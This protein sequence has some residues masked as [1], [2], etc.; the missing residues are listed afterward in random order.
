MRARALVVIAVLAAPLA[1]AEQ[2]APTPDS[3]PVFGVRAGFG[4]P[5]G[6]TAQR[7]PEV[8]DLVE[9]K[10]PFEIELGYRV[11]R[12]VWAQVHFELAPASPAR[13][14]C[15]AGTSCSASDVRFGVMMLLRLLPG[16]RL[17]PWIGAG[18]GVEVLNAE[19]LDAASRVRTEW[20]W[21][22]VEL[23]FVEAGADLRIADRIGFGPWISYS[24]AR[25]TSESAQAAGA[26]TTSGGVHGRTVHHW[27]SGGL[28]AT[29][30]L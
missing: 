5:Y 26:A 23:P 20:S 2:L 14:L 11:T 3:G 24:F 1:R 12:R 13:A 17:D 4:L 28:Q 25:F 15:A 19:G 7:E 29:L 8:K 6:A 21:A 16:A 27:L 22:G 30:K 10:V 18:V 9:R